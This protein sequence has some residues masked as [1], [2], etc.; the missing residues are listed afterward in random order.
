MRPHF[1]V[2]GIS[3]FNIGKHPDLTLL[4]LYILIFVSSS[5]APPPQFAPQVASHDPSRSDGEGEF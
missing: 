5:F 4:V 3:K 1:L 2:L